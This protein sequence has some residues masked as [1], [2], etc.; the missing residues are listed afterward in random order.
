MTATG[1]SLTQIANGT[2]CVIAAIDLSPE[3]RERMFEL[4]LLVGTTIEVVRYAPLGDP[5]EVKVRGYR[6]MIPRTD[7]ERIFV[8]PP[9]IENKG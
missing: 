7:A 5:V 1:Q 3:A 2:K 8:V 4:G 9:I 6:L